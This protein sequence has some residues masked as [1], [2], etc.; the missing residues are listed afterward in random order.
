VHDGTPCVA[1]PYGPGRDPRASSGAG[2]EGVVAGRLDDQRGLH[3]PAAAERTGG[4]G[5]RQALRA[6]ARCAA[7]AANDSAK[8]PSV[9]VPCSHWHAS[10]GSPDLCGPPLVR[11][12]HA[13]NCATA[14]CNKPG[15]DFTGVNV[16]CR[17]DPLR[18]RQ[19]R[20]G[21]PTA[22]AARPLTP[23][24]PPAAGAGGARLQPLTASRPACACRRRGALCDWR[25]ASQAASRGRHALA[26]GGR[27]E[28]TPRGN[29]GAVRGDASVRSRVKRALLF[30]ILLRMRATM[31]Q[32]FRQDGSGLEGAQKKGR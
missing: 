19:R 2:C 3:T 6:G 17:T 28:G 24:R 22:L 10:P 21:T 27:L 26:C 5:Q 14:I 13:C 23:A 31:S 16:R 15:S 32:A 12:L 1:V 18:D 8:N 11:A 25:E 9:R 29:T 20:P 30:P 7:H 4:M